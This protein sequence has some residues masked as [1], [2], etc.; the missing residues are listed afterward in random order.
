MDRSADAHHLDE[1][2]DVGDP[3]VELA[4]EVVDLVGAPEAEM[5]GRQHVIVP[6][7]CGELELPGEFSRAAILGRMQQDDRRPLAG[8]L[9]SRLQVM[10]ADAV[11]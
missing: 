7:E 10:G 11:D 8:M 6:A 1:A 5:V 4:A 2:A 9:A 3:P